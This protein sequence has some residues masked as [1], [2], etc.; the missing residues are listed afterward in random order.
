MGTLYVPSENL[1]EARQ[2]LAIHDSVYRLTTNY[3]FGS[4]MQYNSSL[5]T[6]E[7]SR[8]RAGQNLKLIALEAMKH[9]TCAFKSG[10]R[11]PRSTTQRN[12]RREYI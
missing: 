3:V 2:I 5:F 7:I 1:R 9:G 11:R 10:E 4:C 12:T 6:P 8:F